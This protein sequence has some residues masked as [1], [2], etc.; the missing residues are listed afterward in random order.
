VTVRRSS[1]GLALAAGLATAA[2]LA[3]VLLPVVAIFA[4]TTPG[5]LL[6]Q[7]HSPAALRALGVSLKTSLIA[8]VAI[9][10]VGT[11]VAYVLARARSRAAGVVTTLL[12]LPLVLPPAVAGIGLLAAFGRNGLL[13]GPL[14]AAGIELPFTQAAVVLALVFVAMPFHVR[15][16]FAAFRSVDPELLAASRTLG[17]GP[18]RTFVRVALPLASPGLTAGAALAWARAL[19]EFGATLLF[20]GSFEGRTQ[21]LPLAIYANLQDFPVALAMAGMLVAVSAGL[22]V[23]VKLALRGGEPFEA[24]LVVA[25]AT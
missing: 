10:V 11:P 19:G 12:E 6:A 20:A 24:P 9:L 14:R 22:L 15:Q 23:G 8:L 21:T 1:G 7:V 13:G 25:P 17:A 18:A 3:F 2:L 4:R 16:A 5:A